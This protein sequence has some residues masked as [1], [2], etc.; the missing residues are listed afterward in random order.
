VDGPDR[1]FRRIRYEDLVAITDTEQQEMWLGRLESFT[2]GAT[3]LCPESYD[4]ILLGPP[5]ANLVERVAEYGSKGVYEA[6]LQPQDGSRFVTMENSFTLALRFSAP[7]SVSH[8]I[9][10]A[11]AAIA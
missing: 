3:H 7:S 4:V 5:T 11:V 8:S 1:I 10:Q 2:N 6:P 9:E